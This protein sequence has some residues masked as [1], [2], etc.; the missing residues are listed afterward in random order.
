MAHYIIQIIG[1]I[2]GFIGLILT[3]IVTG[4]P[5]W[6]ISIM[7]ESNCQT[8]QKRIDGQWMTRW[9]GLWSTC[10]SQS[11]MQMQ[12]NSYD[13]LVTVTADLKAGRVLMVF[14]LILSIL[15]FLT[16]IMGMLFSHYFRKNERGKYYLITTAGTAFVLAALLVLIPV[17]WTTHSIFREYDAMCKTSQRLEMGEAIFLAWPT[18]LFLLIAGLVLCCSRPRVEREDSSDYTPSV[19]HSHHSQKSL[20]TCQIK[21]TPSVYS[22]SQYI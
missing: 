11:N 4:M 1:I 17:S 5:Q 7:V 12:C 19:H 16:A 2:L 13:S 14:A 9:D 22:K 10:I 8:A 3:G 20:Y 21:K 15:A 18:I 6:R